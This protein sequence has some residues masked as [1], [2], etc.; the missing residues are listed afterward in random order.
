MRQI[1]T[2]IT[3]DLTNIDNIS[4]LINYAIMQELKKMRISDENDKIKNNI[5]CSLFKG[6]NVISNL[7]P[8][9]LDQ[10]EYNSK[11]I[12][13]MNEL[14]NSEVD[15]D[16]FR[17]SIL[18]ANVLSYSDASYDKPCLSNHDETND[19]IASLVTDSL[20]SGKIDELLVHMNQNE[21]FLRGMISN[22]INVTY[23]DDIIL[24]NRLNSIKN[25][26]PLAIQALEAITPKQEIY[27][28]MQE[29]YSGAH[30]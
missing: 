12:R 5:L 13:N 22:Y 23:H 9:P 4:N 27:D 26:N 7:I 17:H 28:E 30:K 1:R 25:L 19:S 15:L 29:T 18:Q 11:G 21:E 14:I 6:K 16:L 2:D 20:A 24:Q 8:V 3:K 10:E